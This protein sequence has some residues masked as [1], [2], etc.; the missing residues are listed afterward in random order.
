M[1]HFT[2]E[3]LKA[4]LS[5]ALGHDH[6]SLIIEKAW[7]QGNTSHELVLNQTAL[8]RGPAWKRQFFHLVKKVKVMRQK[9]GTVG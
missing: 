3:G 1:P 9:E 5:Q 7:C 6:N 4:K 8:P 2:Y